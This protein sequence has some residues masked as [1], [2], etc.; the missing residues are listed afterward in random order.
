M[1]LQTERTAS[2]YGEVWRRRLG[3]VVV[4][5]F[6]N[7]ISRAAQLHPLANPDR[8]AVEVIRDI[9]YR[10]SGRR[11]HLLDIYRPAGADG[12]LPVVLYAHGGGFR[13]LSKDTH[14][15]MG[16]A[17]ARQ[18]FVVVNINYRLAPSH[19]FPAAL[20][21]ACQAYAWT[22]QNVARYGGDPSRLVIA[23]ESAGANIATALT[24]SACF[25]RPERWA[26]TVFETEVVP[27]A[28]IAACGMLQ[29]S[30][31]ARLG[32]RRPLPR[33]LLDRLEEVGDAYLIAHRPHGPGG[34]ELA[35]PL[36]ILENAP[37]P[38]RTL[39]PFFAPVGTRDPLL[40][41]TRRLTAA[42][43]RLGARCDARYYPGEIHAFHAFLWRAQAR[44]CWQE[45]FDFLSECM[46]IEAVDQAVEDSAA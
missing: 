1:G 37:T 38:L 19:P 31:I 7:G 34:A 9:P 45:C 5:S 29:V 25:E 36:V 21:D 35:D 15:L 10:K 2:N 28:V 27:R 26:N 16:L 44:Q 33:W 40:D 12:S 18:G 41:D 22:I 42:L 11:E 17:F 46:G 20:E 4:D 30:D 13:I 6:F 8:H 14:W 39:P 24:I 43:E 23:G 3:G 32:R